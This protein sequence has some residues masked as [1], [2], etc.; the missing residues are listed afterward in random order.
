MRCRNS[1]RRWQAVLT[2][3]FTR[4]IFVSIRSVSKQISRFSFPLGSSVRLG[5]E[6][7]MR[8]KWQNSSL[9]RRENVNTKTHRARSVSKGNN[10][11][12]L[13]TRRALCLTRRA[14]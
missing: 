5:F 2:A 9:L 14:L 11:R 10:E 8:A 3:A 13:L 12:T 4:S 1:K 6:G 7:Q